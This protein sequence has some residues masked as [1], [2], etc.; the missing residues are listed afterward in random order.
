MFLRRRTIKYSDYISHYAIDAY[1][2]TATEDMGH[3]FKH[4]ERRRMQVI[5]RMVP[6]AG[7]RKVLDIGC[8]NGELSEILVRRGMNVISTDLGFNS[9]Q[10]ASLK[11]NDRLKL[12]PPGDAS[13]RFVQG[14]IYRL[15]YD[16]SSFDAVVASE[17]VEHLDN[18]RDAVS[19]VARVLRPGGYFIVSTPYKEQ[20]R[21]TLCIH[22]NEKTPVNAHLHSFDEKILEDILAGAG[23]T[24]SRISKYS[25][26]FAELFRIPG[27]TFFLPYAAWRLLDIVM[28]GLLGKQSFIVIKA[29]HIE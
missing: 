11:I 5:S 12:R 27:L 21:Y 26:R 20:L 3:S 8:G 13:I 15:P 4:T 24:V 7:V 17:I 1:D 10:R 22:C 29:K 16:D 18:P 28:C 2:I 9:I 25:S 6:G 19:E 23:F 14:D